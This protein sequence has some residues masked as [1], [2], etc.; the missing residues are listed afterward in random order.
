MNNTSRPYV[1]RSRINMSEDDEVTLWTKRLGISRDDLEKAVAKVGN[2]VAAVRSNSN[3]PN[4]DDVRGIK[5]PGQLSIAGGDV[6]DSGPWLVPD[7]A[8]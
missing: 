8:R 1:D 3:W 7:S 2:S 6:H 5:S 4:P